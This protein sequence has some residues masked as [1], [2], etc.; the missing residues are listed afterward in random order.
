MNLDFFVSQTLKQN[1]NKN[2]NPRDVQALIPK[3]QATRPYQNIEKNVKPKIY[4]TLMK[5]YFGE[6]RGEWKMKWRIQWDIDIQ[7]KEQRK[8]AENKMIQEWAWDQILSMTDHGDEKYLFIEKADKDYIILVF[9]IQKW[10]NDNLK[11][12]PRYMPPISLEFKFYK[13]IPRIIHTHAV[14]SDIRRFIESQFVLWIKKN[15]R[16]LYHSKFKFLKKITPDIFQY[17]VS[18]QDANIMASLK[19]SVILG[20]LALYTAWFHKKEIDKKQEQDITKKMSQISDVKQ[21]DR[22]IKRLK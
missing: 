8:T 13:N 22:Y 16:K 14:D 12:T 19:Y 18:F 10:F 1:L 5:Y 15:S 4:A 21:L 11:G 3:P 20:S 2:Q 6:D 9:D 17:K 7:G